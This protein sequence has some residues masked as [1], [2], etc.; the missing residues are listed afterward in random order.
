MGLYLVA[1]SRNGGLSSLLHSN[2]YTHTEK[3]KTAIIKSRWL[4]SHDLKRV[5]GTKISRVDELMQ[6]SL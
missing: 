6:I 2:M 1:L 5:K 3:V 4:R